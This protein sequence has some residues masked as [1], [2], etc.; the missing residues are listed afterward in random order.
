MSSELSG[1][2]KLKSHP[3]YNK[4]ENVLAKIYKSYMF[5]NE[6]EKYYK[7]YVSRVSLGKKR[8]PPIQKL[9][10]EMTDREKEIVKDIEK[11]KIR[12]KKEHDERK[13]EKSTR[14]KKFV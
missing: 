10:N 1:T 2:K 12:I 9:S 14:K 6:N 13:N 5:P 8:L 4:K 11:E 7:D 3:S